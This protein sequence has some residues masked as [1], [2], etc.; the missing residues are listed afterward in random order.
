MVVLALAPFATAAELPPS[1]EG[2][3]LDEARIF[4]SEPERL[5]ALSQRLTEFSDRT[6]FRL[7]VACHGSLIGTTPFGQAIRLRDEWLG[8]EPGMV[9]VMEMDGGKWELGW[10]EVRTVLTESGDE[11]P[12]LG[13]AA[14]SPQDRIAIRNR[15]AE[16]PP[17]RAGSMQDA[18]TFIEVLLDELDLALSEEP[19][20]GPRRGHVLILG[21][22]LL[23]GMLLVAM[24]VYAA[25][26]RADR[27]AGDRFVFPDVKVEPRLG[28]PLG[29]GKV[30][31]RSFG[32]SAS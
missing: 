13:P 19:D 21:L 26:R 14:V 12:V 15:L 10:Q 25:V 28:A 27:I 30:N 8:E 24:L 3:I 16:L 17:M 23:A 9:V 11:V 5:A 29:G 6:G 32:P 20:A 1:P 7:E 18:E 4:A 2:H 31:S 22:G